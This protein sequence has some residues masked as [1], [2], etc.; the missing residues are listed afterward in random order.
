MGSPSRSSSETH[1]APKNGATVR[2]Y[3]VDYAFPL[4]DSFSWEQ[5]TGLTSAAELLGYDCVWASDHFMLGKA[6]FDPWMVLS[7]LAGATRTLKLGTFMSCDGF[8]NPALVAK[9]AA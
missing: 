1:I 8:S 5:L 9:M 2:Y 7:A 3:P 4:N 6:N